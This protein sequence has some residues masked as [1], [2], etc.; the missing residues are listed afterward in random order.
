[1]STAMAERIRS[2]VSIGSGGNPALRCADCEGMIQDDILG[3][4]PDYLEM[5]AQGHRCDE[6][7]QAKYILDKAEYGR[8]WR[9]GKD[10]Q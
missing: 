1:M 2:K 7:E 5:I 4:Y 6:A 3:C 9:K 10:G 8:N